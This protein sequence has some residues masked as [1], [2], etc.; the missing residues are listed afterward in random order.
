MST[1]SATGAFPA[2][3]RSFER[4]LVDL[5]EWRDAMVAELAAFRRWAVVA[6]ILD[7]HSAARLAHLERRLA[8]ERLTIA[9]VAEYSRGKS[10][11]INALF[12]ADL[13]H[14]LL[15]SGPGHTTLCATEIGW[16]PARAPTLRLLPIGTRETPKALR[17]YIQDGEGWTEVALD[18]A[19]PETLAAACDAVTESIEVDAARA[20]DL[21]FQVEGAGLARI[22]RWRYAL[23]NLPHPLLATGLAILD[24]PGHNTLG[25]EP[26]LTLHRL[27]D[28][29]AIVF[30]L[31]AETGLAQADAELWSE[32][33]AP[34]DGLDR[35]CFVVLNKIDVLRGAGRGEGQV[36]GE[37]DR[38]VRATAE[39]LAIEPTRVFA[40][41]AR[42]ALE[43]RIS[44]DG[45]GLLKSRMYRLEQ[46]LARGT[47]HGRRLD[48]A[49]AVQ[50]ELRGVFTEAR[51]L[52]AS[53]LEYT[54]EQAEALGALQGKNQ[55]LVETLAKKASLER[56]RI[57]QARAMLMG[58]KTLH[59]RLADELTRLLD[60]DDIRRA[61]VEARRA[62]MASA[63]SKGIGEALDGF[64]AHSRERM[65]AAVASIADVRDSLVA[66]SRN[67]ARDY[68]MASIEGTEF[69]TERFLVEIDRIEERCER[70]FRST[71][72]LI[73]HR[74]KTLAALF[75]DTVAQQMVRVFEIADRETRTWMNAFVRP[76]ESQVNSFQDNAN[77]R[78]EGMGRI[79]NAETD[80]LERMDELNVIAGE[81]A[82][83][84]EKLE[85]FAQRLQALGAVEAE[86]SLA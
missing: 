53:R 67:F 18:P 27:P 54:R 47:I 17:E 9:F 82:A 61:G 16:D 70:D 20:A 36:L 42:Q 35:N 32:H 26:E 81:V 73:L 60:P 66:Q 86:R 31:T 3:A 76:L 85:G 62:V 29:A 30:M 56:S 23:V 40:M 71:A 58:L 74:R 44:G 45:D 14:R 8:G 63:F 4:A 69:T 38:Q 83:H 59:N 7:E 80:L 79:Q 51:A 11:L 68:R 34:I 84:R 15:P 39:A 64:F 77:S 33:I 19:R 24:T 72:S 75:F 49:R 1:L 10:E 50:A 57:E 25:T 37:I 43:A 65:T 78:I 48:H 21:G 52:L 2:A 22:P 46:A 13:G 55:K 41:S 28:A 5:K 12:F 6:R